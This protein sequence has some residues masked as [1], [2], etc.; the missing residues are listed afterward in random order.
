[1]T[2]SQ[3]KGL[4]VQLDKERIAEVVLEDIIRRLERTNPGSAILKDVR[5]QL[6]ILR[7]GS[8]LAVDSV[9]SW[10]SNQTKE[11]LTS[12]PI[13]ELKY[14]VPLFTLLHS[15]EHALTYQA[16]LRT[17]LEESA[18]VGKVLIDDCAL[19]IFEREQVEAGGVEYLA[20]DLL[21]RWLNE[22]MKRV[23]DCR[24]QCYDGCVT[25]LYIRDPLCHPFFPSEVPNAYIFP[26]YLLSRT[27]LL[28]FWGI[29]ISP[30]ETQTGNEI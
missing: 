15:I 13:S 17:G 22:S 29:P 21:T 18:F 24:Y 20:Y 28:K 14:S 12:A 16:S 30:Y 25:C 19:L 27:L 10:I 8:K 9:Y 4:V 2:Q 6:K 7:E 11:Y 1:M 26:N 23:R 5:A 3:G